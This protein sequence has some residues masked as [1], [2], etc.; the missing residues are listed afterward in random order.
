MF[1]PIIDI[2]AP[3]KSGLRLDSYGLP[4]Q[5][6]WRRLNRPVYQ[7][8]AKHFIRQ[9]RRSRSGP[10]VIALALLAA[11]LLFFALASLYGSVGVGVIYLLPLGL[12]LH[13]LICSPQWLYRIVALISRQARLDEASVIPA[14]R[15]FIYLAI[16]QLVLRQGDALDGTTLLRKLAAG[17]VFA[18]F[19]MTIF[20]T[21]IALQTV[22]TSRLARLLIELSLLSLLIIQE[23]KQSVLFLCLLPM[24]LE[25]RLNGPIDG[26]GLTLACYAT[27][28]VMSCMIAL[29]GP[30]TLQAIAQQDPRAMDITALGLGLSLILF[31]LVRELFIWALWRAALHQSNAE[32]SVLRHRT[33][34]GEPLGRR[35]QEI[36]IG[37]RGSLARVDNAR[38]RKPAAQSLGV[39]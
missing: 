7:P 17:I 16:C 18:A 20:F 19:A 35:K 3:L 28:Q 39:F 8:I 25:R 14:G 15:V 32:S 37:E 21:L 31:L 11:A 13:S 6:L 2:I 5:R 34:A 30:V 38:R 1:P 10:P 4:S 24:A 29:A 27:L 36:I 33:A 9:L 22:D 26:A 23:H 12:S